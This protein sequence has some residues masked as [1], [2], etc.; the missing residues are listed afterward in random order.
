MVINLM[1]IGIP[2]NLLEA[3]ND[4]SNF[5]NVRF[6]YVVWN[7][8]T[9]SKSS[10]SRMDVVQRC[11]WKANVL[12]LPIIQYSTLPLEAFACDY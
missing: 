12:D 11:W 8:N 6:Q 7:Q 3:M 9:L 4:Q 10:P 1:V 2:S 5:S